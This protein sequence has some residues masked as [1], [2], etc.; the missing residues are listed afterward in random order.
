VPS[1]LGRLTFADVQ[2]GR[3]C[4]HDRLKKLIKISHG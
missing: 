2:V 3:A 1:H 4:R